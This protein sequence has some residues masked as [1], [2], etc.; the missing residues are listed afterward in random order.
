MIAS[1][2]IIDTKSNFKMTE[3]VFDNMSV[4]NL[5]IQVREYLVCITFSQ[6]FMDMDA[7][8]YVK[9]MKST[10]DHWAVFFDFHKRILSPVHVAR[11][12]TEAE[13]KQQ[14]SQCDGEKKEWDWGKYVA[15]YKEQ[16]TT[17][18]SLEAHGHSA[19][20]EGTKDHH[21][22]KESE[23]LSW[24]QQSMLFGS[25]QKSMVRILMLQCRI[26]VK[27]SPRLAITWNLSIFP[28]L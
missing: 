23:E 9:Q 28:R 7:H 26:L 12:A 19:I 17:M 24:R 27:W 20:D 10:Q 1:V 8:V 15:L 22:L 16:H 2:H 25:N 21:F 6:G 5:I 13:K 11:H 18:K 4:G 14:N 3:E